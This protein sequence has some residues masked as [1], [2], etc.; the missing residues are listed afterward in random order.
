MALSM[1]MGKKTPMSAF[2]ECLNLAIRV[3]KMLQDS[4]NACST[5]TDVVPVRSG[6][7]DSAAQNA[8]LRNGM[9]GSSAGISLCWRRRAHS[10][11]RQP[12]CR[13]QRHP[14]A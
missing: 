1:I 8:C 7:A 11:A 10:S 6:L 3:M 12:W 13:H 2:R 5:S 14:A 9:Q 4:A